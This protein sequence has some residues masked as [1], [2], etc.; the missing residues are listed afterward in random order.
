MY[1]ICDIFIYVIYFFLIQIKN[2]QNLWRALFMLL[3]IFPPI[4]SAISSQRKVRTQRVIG[5]DTGFKAQ[6]NFH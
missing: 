2:D 5:R 1:M 6:L 3:V 4:L